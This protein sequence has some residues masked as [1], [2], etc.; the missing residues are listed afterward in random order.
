MTRSHV[1][2]LPFVGLQLP[3]VHRTT[4]PCLHVI[5]QV[6]PQSGAPLAVQ[7]GPEASFFLPIPS[8]SARSIGVLNSSAGSVDLAIFV[9]GGF[10]PRC[11]EEVVYPPRISITTIGISMRNL[12][13]PQFAG[14]GIFA[15][16]WMRCADWRA[17]TL[18]ASARV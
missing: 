18:V 2:A 1:H 11:V 13:F 15:S 7:L 9:R 16:L 5:E 4:W 8:K 3:G 10:A 14:R 17:L 12:I 6:P